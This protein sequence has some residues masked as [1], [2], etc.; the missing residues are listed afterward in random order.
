MLL[1]K[2]GK[3]VKS[4][5]DERTERNKE[6]QLTMDLALEFRDELEQARSLPSRRY[7]FDFERW[8]WIPNL[9][10]IDDWI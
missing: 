2:K 9:T 1:Q 8:N 3:T 6:E 10:K 5:I 7:Y 4:M